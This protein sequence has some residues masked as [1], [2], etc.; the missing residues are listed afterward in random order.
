MSVTGDQ[1]TQIYLQNRQSLE[2]ENRGG[3]R[4]ALDEVDILA[5]NS[6]RRSEDYG[7]FIAV[8]SRIKGFC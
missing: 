2:F 4:A 7:F 6:I 3:A 8:N 5:I 1:L